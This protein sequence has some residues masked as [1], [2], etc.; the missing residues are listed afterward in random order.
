MKK[1]FVKLYRDYDDRKWS[2]DPVTLS[3]FIHCLW[4]ARYEE[5]LYNGKVIPRGSFMISISKLAEK[6]GA[7]QKAIRGAIER[8]TK[9]K[10]LV[11]K[12][13]NDGTMITI[14]NYDDYCTLAESD[15]RTMGEQWANDGVNDGRTMG[16][17]IGQQYKNNIKEKEEEKDIIIPPISPQ[18]GEQC[19]LFSEPENEYSGESEKKTRKRFS[20]PTIQEVE[21]YCKERNNGISAESFVAFYESKGWKVGNSPMKDWKAAI[22][23]WEK[24]NSNNTNYGT[25]QITTADERRTIIRS[26]EKPGADF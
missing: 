24:R 2:S 20:P 5:G 14:C 21:E 15:G 26:T 19:N 12:G 4:M 3:T 25:R 17:T 22:I 9:D 16:Q 10:V 23:T 1:G 11:T 18:R 6:I 13:A 8:L 7:S